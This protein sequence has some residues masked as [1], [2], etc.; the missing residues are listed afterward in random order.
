MAAQSVRFAAYDGRGADL[1]V[2]SE[3]IPWISENTEKILGHKWQGELAAE[4][5]AKLQAFADRAHRGGRKVRFWNTPDREDAWAIL[6]DMGVD[7][8]NTDDLAGLAKFL[9]RRASN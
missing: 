7:L 9:R 1:D 8:I 5:R 2:A 3:M 6:A 4:D